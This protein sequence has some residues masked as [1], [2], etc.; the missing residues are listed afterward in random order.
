MKLTNGFVSF[1][2]TIALSLGQTF[3]HQRAAES[4]SPNPVSISGLQDRVSSLLVQSKFASARWG[5]LIITSDG[6][7]IYERDADKALTLASNMTLYTSTAALD[8]FG[9]DF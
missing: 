1:L 5:V 8:A 4:G 6:K 9:P 3:A 7:V 2:L